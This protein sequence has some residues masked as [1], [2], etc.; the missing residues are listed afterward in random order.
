[1]RC[2][3]TC[4]DRA[5]LRHLRDRGVPAVAA[6]LRTLPEPERQAQLAAIEDDDLVALL[7]EYVREEEATDEDAAIAVADDH[8]D[9]A[10]GMR[11]RARAWR[12]LG[13]QVGDRRW[14]PGPQRRHLYRALRQRSRSR[15]RRSTSGT[16]APPGEPAAPAAPSGANSGTSR[17][18]EFSRHLSEAHREPIREAA[19]REPARNLNDLLLLASCE[20]SAETP[21]RRRRE[22][23][24]MSNHERK[25]MD[26]SSSAKEIP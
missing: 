14:T 26:G 24:Q 13:R 8:P 21:R 25:S 2:V 20:A 9:L 11:G 6:E 22:H 17:A 12:R 23:V 5:Q 16:P 15:R 19:V 4:E 10:S 7:E 3:V 1:M 18:T